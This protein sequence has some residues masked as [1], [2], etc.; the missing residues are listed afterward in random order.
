M[1]NRTI[2]LRICVFQKPD[3][4]PGSGHRLTTFSP[5]VSSV[6]SYATIAGEFLGVESYSKPS[7]LVVAF[8]R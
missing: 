5:S 2:R 7:P 1:T 3:R 8:R 6:S 4:D